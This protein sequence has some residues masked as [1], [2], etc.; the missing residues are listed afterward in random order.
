MSG[1]AELII[2]WQAVKYRSVPLVLQNVSCVPASDV[3]A[4]EAA[5]QGVT[6]SSLA[7]HHAVPTP[8]LCRAATAMCGCHFDVADMAADADCLQVSACSIG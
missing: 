5:F 4:S 3:A 1:H 7:E 2:S 6:V 8:F